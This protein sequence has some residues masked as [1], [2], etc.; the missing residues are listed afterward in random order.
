MKMWGIY[1]APVWAGSRLL[2]QQWEARD[3]RPVAIGDPEPAGSIDEARTKIPP[4][5]KRRPR[6]SSKSEATGLIETWEE[7]NQR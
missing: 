3:G 1:Y 6:V 7:V 4:G 5:L 2:V